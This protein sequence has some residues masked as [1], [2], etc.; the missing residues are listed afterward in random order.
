M[1]LL[2]ALKVMLLNYAVTLALLPGLYVV[3]TELCVTNAHVSYPVD[4]K[5]SHDSNNNCAT[6][7]YSL[8]VK[9]AEL[10]S[11]LKYDGN[12]Y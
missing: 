11:S 3:V 6:E 8:I 1:A 7:A 12:A 4:Y 10:C 5:R 9:M 2:L